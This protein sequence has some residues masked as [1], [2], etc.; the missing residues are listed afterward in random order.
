MAETGRN[1]LFETAAAGFPNDQL[2]SW[3]DRWLTGQSAS[4][5]W[6]V[7]ADGITGGQNGDWAA[8][9]A[10]SVA[11]AALTGTDLL[12]PAVMSALLSAH[13]AVAPWYRDAVGGTTLSIATLTCDRL[14]GCTV[15]DSPVFADD[16][17]SLRQLS[18]ATPPGPLLQ[19]VGQQ[20]PVDPWLDSWPVG[21]ARTI[22]VSS[23]GVHCEGV[24]CAER[25]LAAIIEEILT[26]RRS[27]N[28]DDSTVAAGRLTPLTSAPRRGETDGRG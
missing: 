28:G 19:W 15:G 14:I 17:E 9:C 16:G 22:V 12:E 21:G 24:P 13:N 7:V 20:E 11:A 1:A 27:G 8:Q 25:G 5:C 4:G 26:N 3:Q 10:A 6:L 23:D 2:H 18:P